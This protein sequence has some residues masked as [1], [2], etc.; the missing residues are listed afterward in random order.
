MHATLPDCNVTASSLHFT[1]HFYF[2]MMRTR[3]TGLQDAVLVVNLNSCARALR[4]IVIRSTAF[5]LLCYLAI[6]ITHHT[7]PWSSKIE[8]R[9]T[10]LKEIYAQ[11][12]TH[13]HNRAQSMWADSVELT[14]EKLVIEQPFKAIMGSSTV[15][16]T[17]NMA[18][19]SFIKAG[20]NLISGTKSGSKTNE[21]FTSKTGSM[22]I[23]ENLIPSGHH[24]STGPI[25]I[26]N[27]KEQMHNT[28]KISQGSVCYSWKN[29][30][31]ETDP[32]WLPNYK[33]TGT[34]FIHYSLEKTFGKLSDTLTLSRNTSRVFNFLP[35]FQNPCW[36]EPLPDRQGE[37]IY[38][39]SKWM[40]GWPNFQQ[41]KCTRTKLS[42]MQKFLNT[43]RQQ[44]RNTR[45]R[46]FPYIIIIGMF[47]SGTTDFY[48][49]LSAHRQVFKQC[50]KEPAYLQHPSASDVSFGKYLDLY[51]HVGQ[52]IRGQQTE[53]G[54]HPRITME[55]TTGLFRGYTERQRKAMP[56]EKHRTTPCVTLPQH[57]KFLSPKTKY[58]LLLRHQPDWMTSCYNHFKRIHKHLH[59]ASDLHYKV[60][61]GIQG[62]RQCMYISGNDT[63][64]CYHKNNFGD[65]CRVENALYYIA[66]KHW[67]EVVG[68]DQLLVIQA[69]RYYENEIP[70]MKKTASFLGIAPYT[71]N[72]LY[73]L[74]KRRVANKTR[75]EK[76]KMRSSTRQLLLKFV[77]KWNIM[78]AQYLNDE[79][80]QWK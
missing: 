35:N 3:V 39:V 51:D 26:P 31:S 9:E 68:A 75:G 1:F 72:E 18:N 37:Q 67:R 53:K 78:L 65:P 6:L 50:V 46:C 64:F 38:N 20:I 76:V 36:F 55:A 29:Y 42:A 11:A 41:R 40:E 28:K 59:S 30:S 17:V 54:R 21:S 2:S 10:L 61:R 12:Y 33:N 13:E 25:P 5:F 19:D 63:W 79:S 70:S 14:E 34:S 22:L 47:K 73:S 57:L 43:D 48:N 23:T 74:R 49:S 60:V 27:T 77:H 16:E 71:D 8:Y 32:A 44:S 24:I 66:V 80:F 62:F 15:N 45:I 58:I 7:Q 69:E 4:L 56:W 52:R